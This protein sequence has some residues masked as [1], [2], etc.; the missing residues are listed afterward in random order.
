VLTVTSP[1][2]LKDPDAFPAPQWSSKSLDELIEVTF[3][4]RMITSDDNPAFLRL[5][6]AKILPS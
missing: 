1:D 6:G 4:G 2:T 5:I 3:Q